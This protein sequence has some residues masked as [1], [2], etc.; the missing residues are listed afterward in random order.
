MSDRPDG[1][2]GADLVECRCELIGDGVRT[3]SCGRIVRRGFTIRIAAGGEAEG[4]EVGFAEKRGATSG[5]LA[6]GACGSGNDAGFSRV[7]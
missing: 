1:G 6:G 7:D 5:I 3:V 2:F 4:D